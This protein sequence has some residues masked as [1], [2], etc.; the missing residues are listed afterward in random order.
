MVRLVVS[1]RKTTITPHLTGQ[2]F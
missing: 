2:L 1:H